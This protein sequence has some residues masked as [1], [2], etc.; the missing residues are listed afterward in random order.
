MKTISFINLK[1]GVAKTV[2]TINMAYA[3]ATFHGKKLLVVDND[4]QGNTSKTLGVH[5]YEHKSI[6]NVL[7]SRNLLLE[8]VIRPTNIPNVHCIPAN[9]SLQHALLEVQLDNLRPQ[10]NRLNKALDTIEEDYDFCIIDNAPDLN[11]STVNALVASDEVIIPVKIDE[12]A[13]DGLGELL[14][15]IEVVQENMN[16]SLTLAGCLI[17][18][19]QRTEAD[20]QG[21]EHL[22]N[23]E[24]LTV[25]DTHIRYS[26]K[27]VESTFARQS[28]IAHSKKSGATLDYIAFVEEYL[29][30]KSHGKE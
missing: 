23:K 16:P 8:E 26:E 15:Q 10:H 5:S 19:Y 20:R 2:S 27:V 1:G 17:T 29:G 28:V 25:F 9:M 22:Q 3:L 7:T 11:M 14:E 13:F 4:K 12:Y 30:G 21:K 6:A 24:N 18:C